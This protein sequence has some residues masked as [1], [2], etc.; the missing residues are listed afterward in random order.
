MR[1]IGRCKQHLGK[2]RHCVANF[3]VSTARKTTARAS[4]RAVATMLVIEPALLRVVHYGTG[5]TFPLLAATS[6]AGIGKATWR[7]SVACVGSDETDGI[8]GCV[9]YAFVM[10]PY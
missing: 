7:G 5:V 2:S 9:T 1:I 8:P 10:I 3:R 4:A 6:L